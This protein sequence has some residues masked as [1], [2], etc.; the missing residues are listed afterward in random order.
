MNSPE[1]IAMIH[2]KIDSLVKIVTSFRDLAEITEQ[3]FDRIDK[4]IK[5]FQ[6]GI[7]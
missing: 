4:F 2:E 3:R 6:E 5:D 7:K 1:E